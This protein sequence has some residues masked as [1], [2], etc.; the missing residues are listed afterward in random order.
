ML[1]QATT[2]F[3]VLMLGLL[4]IGVTLLAA[5]ILVAGPEEPYK[6]KR[7]EAGNPP[8]G[9]AKKRLPYQYYGYILLYLAVEPIFVLLY[10]LPYLNSYIMFW[11]NLIL[12]AVYGPAL[13]YAVRL[14]ERIELWGE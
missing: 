13:L 6:R 5:K 7:Y 8:S 4:G 9:E 3:T 14:A 2:V 1:D 11:V 12:L 10:F